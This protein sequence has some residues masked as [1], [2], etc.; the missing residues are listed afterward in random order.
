ME[1]K[2]ATGMNTFGAT[3]SKL[4]RPLSFRTNDTQEDKDATTIPH[5]RAGSDPDA[6]SA[7]RGGDEGEFRYRT[8]WISDVHLGTRGC[9]AD[10]LLDFM[11]QTDS[12][13]LYLVGDIVDG[14]RLKKTWYWN[15]SQNDVIQK[16]LR[17]ARKGTEVIYV[18]GNHDEVLRDYTSMHFGGVA[19]ERE[20]IHLTA[21]GRR[22]LVLHGDEFDG[23]V[24][25]A[26]WL[27]FL[28]DRA[29]NVALTANHWFN[30]MRR[31]LGLPY[32]SL[33]AYLKHKV[34]NAVEFVSRFE[35]T[36]AAEARRRGVDGVVCGHIHHAEMRD[37]DGVLYCND[38][39]WVESCSALVEHMDG[40][41]E[42]IRFAAID[43]PGIV[44][45]P[46]EVAS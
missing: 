22:L 23:V 20:A 29:Y 21:D 30:L 4:S 44:S 43:H 3:Y 10:Y 36:V 16:I 2:T 45:Q 13:Y 34:K 35:R 17:K 26:R 41:L 15:Q 24:T 42:I 11:R 1:L 9:K 5:H 37:I 6:P 12:D 28:G 19:V 46:V 32:W 18:P 40:R 14:W 33:S 25:Y 39:D 38:G 27:A 31:A 7:G 8:I